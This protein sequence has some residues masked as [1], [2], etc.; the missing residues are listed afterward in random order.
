MKRQSISDF[1][2]QSERLIAANDWGTQVHLMEEALSAFPEEPE[3]WIRHGLAVYDKDP[4][5]AAESARRAAALAGAD[6]GMLTR[7]ASLLFNLGDLEESR[8]Y[9]KRIVALAPEDFSLIPDVLH[10][11]GKLADRKGNA[12]VAETYL[13]KAFEVDPTGIGH[14]R[15][16]AEF[17]LAHNRHN[18]ALDVI[19]CGLEHDSPDRAKLLQ[20]RSSLQDDA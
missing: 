17:F 18:E 15:V 10:L 9:V 1:L 11:A 8:H 7:C 16:L 13:A 4:A 2:A 14:A 20:L 19:A 6:V 3:F 5:K 12:D